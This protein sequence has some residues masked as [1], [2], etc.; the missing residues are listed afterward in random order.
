MPAPV[1]WPSPLAAAELQ[2]IKI[3]LICH[4]VTKDDWC[5]PTKVNELEAALKQSRSQLELYRPHAKHAFMS[6]PVPRYKT[7]YPQRS[8]GRGRS[9]S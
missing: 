8:R 7:R 3:P 1:L 9:S 6:K 5:T 4:F 2:K